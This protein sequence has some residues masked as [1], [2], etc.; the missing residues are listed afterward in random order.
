MNTLANN[1][2][3][4]QLIP[5]ALE[6][7]DACTWISSEELRTGFRNYNLGLDVP[8][9]WQNQTDN[10]HYR[11]ASRVSQKIVDHEIRTGG[12]V[13]AILRK[14]GGEFASPLYEGQGRIMGALH[15]SGKEF[16]DYPTMMRSLGEPGYGVF[17]RRRDMPTI[18]PHTNYGYVLLGKPDIEPNL[19]PGAK[20]IAGAHHQKGVAGHQAYG[21][22]TS[23]ISQIYGQGSTRARFL[24]LVLNATIVGD[25]YDATVTRQHSHFGGLEQ[26]E[27][28]LKRLIGAL[29]PDRALEV[30]EALTE[31]LRWYVHDV[32]VLTT[33]PCSR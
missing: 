22:G 21:V 17:D 11:L 19:P 32:E 29:F 25:V 23:E 5:L 16:V 18:M 12:Y 15:D 31:E 14:V 28:I 10:L 9:E 4:T 27:S 7:P 30:A 3:S 2:E 8:Y 13:G 1:L 24:E 26:K 20:I 6:Y 33:Q